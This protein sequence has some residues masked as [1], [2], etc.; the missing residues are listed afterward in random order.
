M[1]DVSSSNFNNKGR[2]RDIVTILLFICVSQL[3]DF[4]KHIT[5]LS[6]FLFMATLRGKCTLPINATI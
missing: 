5:N 2:H 4:I 6:I 1:K 3:L